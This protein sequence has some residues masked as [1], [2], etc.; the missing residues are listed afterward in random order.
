M[1]AAGTAVG[2]LNGAL[3]RRRICSSSVKGS[4]TRQRFG[5]DFYWIKL[6]VDL[7]GFTRALYIARAR[8]TISDDDAVLIRRGFYLRHAK[9][10]AGEQ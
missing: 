2:F 10:M 1:L 5:D 8:G 3:T 7:D 6:Q 9:T 4:S